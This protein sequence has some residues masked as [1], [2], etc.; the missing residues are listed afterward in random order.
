MPQHRAASRITCVLRSTNLTRLATQ[1]LALQAT[2]SE[3]STRGC[4]RTCVATPYCSRLTQKDVCDAQSIPFQ[5]KEYAQEIVNG[6]FEGSYAPMA[7]SGVSCD[8][9]IYAPEGWTVE[10]STRNEND[11]TSM[12]S[13]G[14]VLQ[15]FLCQQ[16]SE[17]QRRQADHVGAPALGQLHHH[18]LPGG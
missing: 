2:N 8:R 9:A 15:Q 11:L 12:K 13:G 17:H 1:R 14:P 5:A 18:S 4:S 7:N 6:D 10:Y 3:S 16:T